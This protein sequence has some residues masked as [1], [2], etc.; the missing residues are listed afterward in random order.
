V[1]PYRGV[2]PD[3]WRLPDEATLSGEVEARTM[4]VEA[5][6]EGEWASWGRQCGIGPIA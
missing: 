6:G 2:S 3:P 1:R 4:M 5:G